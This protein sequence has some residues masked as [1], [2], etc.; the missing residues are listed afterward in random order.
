MVWR[1]LVWSGTESKN[2]EQEKMTAFTILSQL[3][4]PPAPL[5]C[6]KLLWGVRVDLP[7]YEDEVLAAAGRI[8]GIDA[9]DAILCGSI[10]LDLHREHCTAE[11][12]ARAS[13]RL[14]KKHEDLAPQLTLIGQLFAG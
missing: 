1:G 13:A 11:Q 4:N 8:G 9:E 5:D 10:V 6:A 7:S 2:Y 14:E 3:L 12:L